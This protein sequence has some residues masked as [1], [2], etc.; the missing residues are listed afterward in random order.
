MTVTMEEVEKQLEEKEY[1]IRALEDDLEEAWSENDKKEERIR[2][3]ELQLKKS[4]ND[5]S[6][7]KEM[8]MKMRTDCSKLYDHIAKLSTSILGNYDGKTNVSTLVD[9]MIKSYTE[10]KEE[11]D[12]YQKEISRSQEKHNDS[13]EI[14]QLKNRIHETQQQLSE[15]GAEI[16]NYKSDIKEMNKEREKMQERIKEMEDE[17]EAM[18]AVM[19]EEDADKEEEERK[20]KEEINGLKNEVESLKKESDGLKKELEEKSSSMELMSATMSEND[21]EIEG[22]KNEV[23]SLKKESDGLKKELEEKS[24]S[25]ELMSATMIENDAEIEGLK[26]E[27]ESLKK[28]SDGLKNELEIVNKDKHAIQ[29]AVADYESQLSLCC[30]CFAPLTFTIDGAYNYSSVF[31][32]V[33]NDVVGSL[34][35]FLDALC[36]YR[37]LVDNLRIRVSQ[38]ESDIPLYTPVRSIDDNEDRLL[39]AYSDLVSALSRRVQSLEMQLVNAD[40]SQCYIQLKDMQSDLL[41]LKR[42]V[43]SLSD[44]SL[45]SNINKHHSMSST[46]SSSVLYR[47]LSDESRVATVRERLQSLCKQ[48][49][50]LEDGLHSDVSPRRIVK[51]LISCVDGMGVSD[52]IE[53]AKTLSS[54]FPFP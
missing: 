30:Y 41:A 17:M 23:E 16:M 18:N 48:S 27:V 32:R 37:S 14:M 25:L 44:I 42:D 20:R 36:Y 8:Y 33:F 1:Q 54:V 24:S 40:S 6:D 4:K 31:S 29:S 5:V 53:T 11:R 2:Q 34:L 46:L 47:R 15:R 26:N 22:L 28:E 7:S 3:M 38:L 39:V 49:Y 13:E 35:G 12:G 9:S 21:A 10:L 51:E 19:E 43:S 52:Y 45:K 50:Q